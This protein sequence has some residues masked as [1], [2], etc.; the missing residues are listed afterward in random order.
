MIEFQ[1]SK[2]EFSLEEKCYKNNVPI[3]INQCKYVNNKLEKRN[4]KQQ[5]TLT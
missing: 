1:W 3:K 5:E 4:P 2:S